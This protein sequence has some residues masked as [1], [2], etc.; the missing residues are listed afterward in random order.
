MAFATTSS[1]RGVDGNI[2]YWH[3]GRFPVKP[4]GADPRLPLMGD[5]T[6]EWVRVTEPEEMPRSINPDQ[7]WLANWNNKPIADWPFAE[8]DF[9]WGEGHRVQV[10]MGAM[11]SWHAGGDLTT[12]HLNQLNQVGGYHHTA[13]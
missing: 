9:H 7:G 8:S 12:A 6:Q 11:T 3:A 13:G 2:G 5:G 10:L 1:G 4:E